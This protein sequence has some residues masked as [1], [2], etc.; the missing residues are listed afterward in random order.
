MFGFCVFIIKTYVIINSKFSLVY[1]CCGTL[2]VPKT[3]M[4]YLIYF[5]SIQSD[6]TKYYPAGIYLPKVNKRNSRTRCEI[7][8]KLTIKI[9]ERRHCRSSVSI[10]NF[11]HVIGDWER[12]NTIL[13]TVYLEAVVTTCFTK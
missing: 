13:C 2:I 12:L 7:C 11:E 4:S 6:M 8:S 1:F 3:V 9:P 10:V 5:E